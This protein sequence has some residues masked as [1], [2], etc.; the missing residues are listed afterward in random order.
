M[1][2]SL[3]PDLPWQYK[4]FISRQAPKAVEAVELCVGGIPERL[5]AKVE[6]TLLERHEAGCRKEPWSGSIDE[7]LYITIVFF[8]KCSQ[9]ILH[10]L[11]MSSFPDIFKWIF[12]NKNVW[13]SIRVSL[14]FV[15]KCQINNIPTLV[16]IMAWRRPGDKP[17]SEPMMVSLLKH[18][19][20]TRP[21]WVNLK[22]IWISC[23]KCSNF[24]HW[25][26]QSSTYT[27]IK[28]EIKGKIISK[29]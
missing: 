5:W 7:P 9:Q 15:P 28:H 24:I 11:P 8:P 13:I 22:W 3:C 1:P 2:L 10:S 29:L 14:K 19:Y 23:T 12:V 21:Q 27:D 4:F 6:F 17:L 18:I 26:C 25:C 20:I 16:Q